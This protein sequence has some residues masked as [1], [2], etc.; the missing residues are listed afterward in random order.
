VSVGI[1]GAVCDCRC[2]TGWCDDC[3]GGGHSGECD[4]VPV[5]SCT[6]LHTV[7]EYVNTLCCVNSTSECDKQNS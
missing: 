4:L 2:L 7:F 1:D 6:E 5:L 3:V